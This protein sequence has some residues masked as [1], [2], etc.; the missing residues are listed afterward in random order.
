M[1]EREGEGKRERLGLEVARSQRLEMVLFM[2]LYFL[3]GTPWNV[4]LVS[5]CNLLK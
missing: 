5:L 3:A 2:R 1:G 4:T